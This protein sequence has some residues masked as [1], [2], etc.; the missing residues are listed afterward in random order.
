MKPRNHS[1]AIAITGLYFIFGAGYQL[2]EDKWFPL[3]PIQIDGL[4]GLFGRQ[5]GSL[6]VC[7]LGLALVVLAVCGAF[8]SNS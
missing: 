6:L 8:S 4:V 7:L 2:L 5:V 1:F 3:F